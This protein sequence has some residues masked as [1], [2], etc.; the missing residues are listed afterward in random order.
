VNRFSHEIS[1]VPPGRE[2]ILNTSTGDESPAYFLVVP[3]GH[4]DAALNAEMCNKD[5]SKFS[6]SSRHS[7]QAFTYDIS[8]DERN[9]RA[10][11]LSR[12]LGR[13]RSSDNQAPGRDSDFLF[14]NS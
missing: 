1:I 5:R 4:T 7:G 2:Q 8:R 12:A 13:H 3:P 11:G 9:L 6:L 14:C 10:N